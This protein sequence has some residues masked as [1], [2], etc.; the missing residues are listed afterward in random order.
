MPKFIPSAG[1]E[2]CYGSSGN[3]TFFHKDGQCFYRKRPSSIPP[4]TPSQLEATELHR[5]ALEAWRTLDPQ[6]QKTWAD[7]GSAVLSHRPPYD[8][9]THITGHNLFVSAYHGF[10][11]LGDEHIPEPAPWEDFPV[12]S[13]VFDSAQLTEEGQ[14]LLLRFRVFLSGIGEPTRYRL[15][16]RAD[17]RHIDEGSCR[18]WPRVFIA[19][20]NCSGEESLVTVA[21]DDFTTVSGILTGQ[22]KVKSRYLLIDSKTGYRCVAKRLTFGFSI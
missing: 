10:A 17:I 4:G 19:G 11:Q 6:T 22:Y 12:F 20:E 8:G 2:D 1:I 16:I 15:H 14:K 9:S 3:L 18:S 7:Y 13:A 5:R 21:I